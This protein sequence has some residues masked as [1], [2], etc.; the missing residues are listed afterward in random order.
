MQKKEGIERQLAER[1][2]VL[3]LYRENSV[4]GLL[5]EER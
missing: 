1:R 5:C 4:S 2:R 3:N